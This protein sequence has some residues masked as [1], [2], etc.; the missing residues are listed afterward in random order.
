MHQHTTR[1]HNH[2]SEGAKKLSHKKFEEYSTQT[3]ATTT[4]PTTSTQMDQDT[5]DQLFALIEKSMQE[6]YPN[7]ASN[8]SWLGNQRDTLRTRAFELPK[9]FDM[10]HNVAFPTFQFATKLCK[11]KKQMQQFSQ[12]LATQISAKITELA[13][14]DPTTI[15]D[16]VEASGPYINF[17]LKAGHLARI[18][19]DIVSDQHPFLA[20][21]VLQEGKENV[22]IEYSQPNTHKTFHV[23][24]MRNAA[25]G[26][27][28]V[29][30]FEFQGHNVN[31]VNYI[32]D[33]G[34]HIAKCLWYYLYSIKG[35]NIEQYEATPLTREEIEKE[36]EERRPKKITKVEW[37]GD[38][39][40]R[41]YNQLDLSMWTDYPHPGII[42]AKIVSIEAH[43]QNPKWKVLGVAT[44]AESKT[45]HT[46]VCGGIN[47]ELNEI[48]AYAPIGIKKAGRLIQAQDMKGVTS[49]GLILSE[50][51][52]GLRSE[53]NMPKDKDDIHEP[54]KDD[55]FIFPSETPSWTICN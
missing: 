33:V 39:Y 54:S 3:T 55:I 1:L 23:G 28:L 42:T 29:Q 50:K 32:G 52:F 48:V 49:H 37:L 36:L 7:E 38:M 44:D 31:A 47:Y 24:H 14:Q 6:L 15:V 53:K 5:K 10:L 41:G 16:S 25:L 45:V 35:T 19:P 12:T 46:V 20:K 26:N 8:P 21:R 11:D 2:F 27:S 51:E 4:Q 34:A 40:Q 9:D 43:P 18:V 22:M 17:Y 13:Q 30:L